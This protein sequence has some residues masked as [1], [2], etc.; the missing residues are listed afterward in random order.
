[1]CTFNLTMNDA[2]V[3][4]VRPTF[5]TKEAVNEWLQNQATLLLQQIVARQNS[6]EV[7]NID[8]STKEHSAWIQSMSKY[9]RLVPMD[10]K[11][12]ILDSLEERFR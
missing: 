4:A 3:E 1:M 7:V 5:K 12:A 9:R 10:D 8:L 6:K 2:L 11:S